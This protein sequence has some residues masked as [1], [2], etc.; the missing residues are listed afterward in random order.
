MPTLFLAHVAGKPWWLCEGAPMAVNRGGCVWFLGALVTVAMALLLLMFLGASTGAP[1]LLVG[2]VAACAPAPFYVAVALW[3]D[4]FE[5]EPPSYLIGAFL[6]GA[7]GAC[8]ISALANTNSSLVAYN[9]TGNAG[10]AELISA[11]IS[12]PLVEEL[13]KG[14][15]LLRLFWMNREE[16]DG[17][18]DGVI[19][20]TMVALGFAMT[21]N[22]LYY[23]RAFAEAG[24]VGLAFITVLRGVMSPYSH[25]LFTCMT[26]IGFG[27]ARQS[28]K[29]L[30]KLFAPVLGFATAVSLHCL[31]NLSASIHVG[32]WFA[33]YLFIMLP[34]GLTILLVVLFSLRRESGIL[35]QHLQPEVD[36]GVLS[37][38]EVATLTSSFGRIGAGFRAFFRGGPGRWMVYEQFSS[39]TS[40]LAFLRHKR[41]RGVLRGAGLD[42]QERQLKDR[43]AVLLAR[44][45]GKA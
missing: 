40:D 32:Y 8:L 19:Y 26:G 45:T 21:E 7:I 13:C 25:P 15:F 2:I 5:P 27:W 10:T 33:A 18:T 37:A 17:I 41:E 44:L 22:I 30:V 20:A 1:G 24:G 38:R 28:D 39:A 9:A 43:V 35:R 11:V 31:W 3:L 12:A 6:W 29:P 16:F 4:R 42:E 23:G 14:L 36:E 34:A